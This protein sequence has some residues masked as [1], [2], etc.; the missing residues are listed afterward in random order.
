MFLFL[1]VLQKNKHIAMHC[2][3]KC[4]RI[5][6]KQA[7]CPFSLPSQAGLDK[8]VIVAYADTVKYFDFISYS[9]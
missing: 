1:C 3:G 2:L 9:W 7:W 6:E 8:S 5:N 4:L